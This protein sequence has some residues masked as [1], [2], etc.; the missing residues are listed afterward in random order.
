MAVSTK[1]EGSMCAASKS[2][3]C[4]GSPFT[5]HSSMMAGTAAKYVPTNGIA[6]NTAASTAKEE[7]TYGKVNRCIF[8]FDA[9]II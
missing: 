2:P 7:I 4:V 5:S 9:E 3:A 6:A 1:Y 8:S